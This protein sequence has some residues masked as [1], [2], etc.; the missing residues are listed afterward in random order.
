MLSKQMRAYIQ[1]N[2]G[3]STAHEKRLVLILAR[4][5]ECGLDPAKNV[6]YRIMAEYWNRRR[7]SVLRI[8]RTANKFY[9]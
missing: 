8:F 7:C 2:F 1:V 3:D 4:D 9:Q 6:S 5:S